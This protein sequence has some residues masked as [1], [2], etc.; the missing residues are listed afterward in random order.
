MAYA[1]V[2]STSAGNASGGSVVI[3]KP[4]GTLDGHLAVVGTYLEP[5]TNGWTPGSGFTLLASQVNTGLFRLDFW[6]KWCSG[7]PSSWTWTPTSNNWRTIVCASYSGGG[8]SG[9]PYDIHGG[10]QGDSVL[11]TS[12][13]APSVTTTTA[14]DLL[15]FLYG[16]YSGTNTTAMGGTASNLRVSFGGLTI[17]DVNRASAGATGTSWPS[18][19]VGTEDYAAMHIALLLTPGGGVTV[20]PIF[21]RYG[22]IVGAAPPRGGVW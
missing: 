18:S 21:K 7:E 4:T 2:A 16:N 15:V 20:Q 14:D 13:T 22:G 19:G 9:N 12:Q 17:A 11:N 5:D 3:N 8:G 10:S 6:Y 1:Y